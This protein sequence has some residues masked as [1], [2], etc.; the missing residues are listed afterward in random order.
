MDCQYPDDMLIDA[1]IAGVREK[2]VQEQLL[3]RGE[4]LTLPEAIENPQQFE[5]SQKQIKI[6]REEEAKVSMVILKPKHIMPCKN[7]HKGQAKPMHQ[8][9]TPDNRQRSS[10]SYGK[11]PEHKWRK[12]KCP[13]KGSV[14][15]YHHKP[16]H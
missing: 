1:I 13:A 4:E 6:V 14:C 3:G 10:R 9:Q 8:N 15:S 2:R 16:N 11:D 12:G 5:M 7:M